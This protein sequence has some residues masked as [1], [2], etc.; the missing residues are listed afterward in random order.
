MEQTVTSTPSAAAPADES[1]FVAVPRVV[2]DPDLWS[3]VVSGFYDRI[4][5][6][7][8][9]PDQADPSLAQYFDGLNRPKQLKHF[10]AFVVQATGGPKQYEGRDMATAHAEVNARTPITG[11]AW[12]RV[13]GHFVATLQAHQVP[14]EY[15]GQLGAAIAPLRPAIVTVDA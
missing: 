4:L 14:D 6:P 12:D 13:I 2:G 10:A 8:D 1:L 11:E 5:G 15:V 7:A 9:R 3:K